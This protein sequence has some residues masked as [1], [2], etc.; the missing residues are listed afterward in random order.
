MP[1]S[2][3]DQLSHSLGRRDEGPNIALARKICL[4]SDVKAIRE[5]IQLI[6]HAAAP[7]AY[8]AIK[9]LYTVGEQKPELLVPYARH[10]VKALQHSDN[11]INWGAMTALS[12]INKSKPDIVAKHL[13]V[14]VDAM[15]KG[16]VITRDHG[17][18]ILANLAALQKYHVAAMELLLEQIE[19][20]PVNQV[21]MYAEKMAGVITLPYRKRLEKI[22]HTRKDVLDIPSKKRRIEKLLILLSSLR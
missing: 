8:D 14:I 9:V 20:A 17:I 11:R 7:I 21:P 15:D 13:P 3:V 22:L 4:R 1:A 6:Q 19:K 10:F 2:I 5:L 12:M 18:Y 16:S